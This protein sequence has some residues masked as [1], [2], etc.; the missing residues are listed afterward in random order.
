MKRR[1]TGLADTP[2][3]QP[4]FISTCVLLAEDLRQKKPRIHNTVRRMKKTASA[5]S[6]FR[7]SYKRP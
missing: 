3:K 2:N 1:P 6:R 5:S 4:V 7:I